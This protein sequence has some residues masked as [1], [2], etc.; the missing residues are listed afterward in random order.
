MLRRISTILH[1]GRAS[2]LRATIKGMRTTNSLSWVIL[3]IT[4]P[5]IGVLS[6]AT[7]A[8]RRRVVAKTITRSLA[9]IRF[10]MIIPRQGATE[11]WLST[12]ISIAALIAETIISLGIVRLHLY[13]QNRLIEEKES[14]HEEAVV[15]VDC[16]HHTP[17]ATPIMRLSR[18]LPGD[19]YL[20]HPSVHLAYI[21]SRYP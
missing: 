7:A 9:T 20:L 11:L 8:A 17:T 6:V 19:R 5:I 1:P 15:D 14:E 4:A 12:T 18:H 13:C 3:R 21:D 16:A 10:I 2:S